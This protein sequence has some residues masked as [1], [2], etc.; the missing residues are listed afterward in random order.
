MEQFERVHAKLKPIIFET[1]RPEI[2]PFVGEIFTWEA[3]WLIEDG[4]YTGDWAMR[5]LSGTIT[6]WVPS[7]DLEIHSI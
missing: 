7:R 4:V 6:R 5:E 3:Q 1:L 2:L